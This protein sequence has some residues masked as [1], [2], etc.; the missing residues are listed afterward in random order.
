MKRKKLQL[1]KTTLRVLADDGPLR[2]VVGGLTIGTCTAF[3]TVTCITCTCPIPDSEG[4]CT[5]LCQSG[6]CGG[7]F[8]PP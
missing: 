3:C 1:K 5:Y 4:P 7:N 6:G 2:H 8:V